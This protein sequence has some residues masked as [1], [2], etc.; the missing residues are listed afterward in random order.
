MAPDWRFPKTSYR[1]SQS[2]PS[3]NASLLSRLMMATFGACLLA[4]DAIGT[5]YY[6][7][8]NGSDSNNGSTTAPFLTWQKGLNTAQAGDIVEV[9]AG[10]YRSQ[11]AS[12]PRSGTSTA[13]ITLRAAAGATVILKGSR[14]V[15]SW[16]LDSGSVYRSDGWTFYFGTWQTNPGDARDKAR[17]QLF[18]NGVYIQEVATRASMVAGSF[19]IDQAAQKLYLWLSDNS[20]PVGKTVEA[21]DTA[22]PLLTTN[23][24]NYINLQGLQ[25]QDCANGPQGSAAVRIS[26]TSANCAAS[27]LSVQ[28]AA[29]AGFDIAGTSNTVTSCVFNYN[30]Q[31]GIHASAPVNCTFEGC[32]SSYNNTLPGKQ[33]D[34]GWEAGG[35]KFALCRN[36]VIDRHLA[37][38]NVGPG[39]WFDVDNEGSTITNCVSY[40]NQQGIMYEISYTAL[41]ANNICYSNSLQGADPNGPFGIGIYVSSSAGCKVFNNTCWG[42][43][44][45]GIRI[46]GGVRGDGSSVPGQN[47]YSYA[48]QIYNNVCAYNQVSSKGSRDYC[49]DVD[50][51]QNPSLNN[52][53]VPYSPNISDY[54]LFYRND[55]YNFF[56]ASH[57]L[58]GSA[59]DYHVL[60]DWQTALGLDMHSVWGDPQFTNTAGA[61]FHLLATSPGLDIGKTL[62]EVLRDFDSVTRTQGLAYDAGA[63]ER[64]STTRLF[65]TE[66]TTV[67]GTSGDTHRIIDDPS[68]SN[69]EGTILDSDAVGDYVIYQLPSVSS[70]T[71]H[72]KV[73]VKK[74]NTRSIWQ[75]MCGRADNFNGTALNVGAPQDEYSSSASFVELDLGTWS[76]T[77]TNDKWFKF[78]VT[79]KN[80]SSA[81]YSMAF[82]YIKL[83]P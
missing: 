27:S 11:S 69:G 48:T 57:D 25:F 50:T 79:G 9:R 3:M 70:G 78:S 58:N 74:F 73:G 23:S 76:P 5:T 81:G 24:Q 15:T 62:A 65:E 80:A 43:D 19:F 13:P 1:F 56:A 4:C 66:L 37:H 71:Y 54:N 6:V 32:E 10:T 41:I 75:L 52:T 12:F 40:R 72:V 2:N 55:A 59:Q 82:D 38:D 33:Y 51:T 16:V 29:G 30:G 31:L 36:L 63:Y 61:D 67:A 47:V 18:V 46:T 45:K 49:I 17:N 14:V 35:N 77:T 83:A 8:T 7:A 28:Y 34:T 42:N 39:I 53:L 26:G 22:G 64:L 60:T 20:S 44:T 21:D 68:F